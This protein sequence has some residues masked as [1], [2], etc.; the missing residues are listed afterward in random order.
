MK[1]NRKEEI[2]QKSLELFSHQGYDGVSMRDI[3]GALGI[4]QSSLYKHYESKQAIFDSIVE[5]MNV[6]TQRQKAQMGFP[7]GGLEAMARGYGQRSIATM[8]VLGEQLYRYWTEDTF[9]SSFRRLLT[10]EQ[11]KGEA[12]SRLYHQYLIQ[13]VLDY[14]TALFTVMV[15]RGH[16]RQGNPRLMGMEFYGPIFLLM[17]AYDH[18]DNREALVEQVREHIEHFGQRWGTEE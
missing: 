13:G 10:L 1:R 15:A 5:R 12:M 3:A 17:C 8:Q 4:R 11:Y 7:T 2:L 9:A 16:F 6:E 18:A 14:N